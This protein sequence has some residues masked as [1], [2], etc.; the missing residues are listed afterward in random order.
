M[1]VIRILASLL[2]FGAGTLSFPQATKVNFVSDYQVPVFLIER[3]FVEDAKSLASSVDI[4]LSS[5]KLIGSA[6][7]TM[8]FERGSYLL[9]VGGNEEYNRSFLLVADGTEKDIRISGNARKAREANFWMIGAGLAFILS[10]Q[11]IPLVKESLPSE[12]QYAPLIL[13]AACGIGFMIGF[14]DWIW[15]IPRVEV[16]D[17]K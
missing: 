2:I 12:F 3:V 4:Q 7:S 1:G 6:P 17:R 10:T 11:A 5:M 13:P 8:D 15:E 16:A 9:N 14:V